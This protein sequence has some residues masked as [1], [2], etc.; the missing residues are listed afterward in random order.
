MGA[1]YLCSVAPQFGGGALAPK[2]AAQKQFHI[3]MNVTISQSRRLTAMLQ[4]IQNQIE[5]KALTAA[6][7]SLTKLSKE[8]GRDP[9]LFLLGTQLALASGNLDGALAAA[10]RAYD[11]AP[12]WHVAQ[13]HL[14]EVFA[15]AGK[16]S[17]AMTM[18]KLAI[19]Q[20]RQLGSDPSA[21]AQLLR[22][23]AGIAQQFSN[24]A[25]AS[26][27][28]EQVLKLIPGD[29]TLQNDFA[30]SLTY[31]GDPKKAISILSELL[32]QQPDHPGLLLN[33]LRA[34]MLAQMP[35][36]AVAD[37]ERLVDMDSSNETYR[38][39]L[40]VARGE[41]PLTQPAAV[42]A[43]L[44]DGYAAHYDDL[45]LKTHRTPVPQDVA[46]LIAT[47]HPEKD[48]DVLD[49]GCGTGLLGAFLGRNQG[50]IVGVDLSTQMLAMAN[51]RGVYDRLHSVNLL[52]ALS[53]TPAD[54][55]HVITLLDVLS[56]VGDLKPVILDAF[57]V[58]V[59]GGR[60]VF[61]VETSSDESV[62]YILSSSY[63]YFYARSYVEQLMQQAGFD[64][65]SL[66]DQVLRYDG[67]TAVQG[68]LVHGRKPE[69]KSETV[70]RKSTKS[71]KR[72]RREQ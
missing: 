66:T 19:G 11:L 39:Y 55:Y 41:T 68:L 54:H 30:R 18:A 42:I 64:E 43:D 36:L 2:I 65:L 17:E 34:S 69:A 70:A 49:L 31:A 13:I 7:T 24:H 8:H 63:L 62:D 16:E 53:A 72:V 21:Q 23:G 14:G 33:R 61:T 29:L 22:K 37:G 67:P 15:K 44:F 58:L 71:A 40:Q 4:D 45:M 3:G 47:W 56:Y 32:A 25:V 51:Q 50:V 59:P 10:R 52:D 1:N 27:W 5:N 46:K 57:K 60:L 12:R 9:R 6:A 38:F 35:Q 28:L 26:Q 20:V 48:A